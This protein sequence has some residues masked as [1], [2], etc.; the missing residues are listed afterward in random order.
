MKFYLDVDLV[1]AEDN[2]NVFADTDQVS[3]PVGDILVRDARGDVKHDDGALA[4]DVVAVSQ[5]AEFLLAGRVPGVEANGAKVGVEG[6]WMDL[7]TQSGY[8]VVSHIL[9]RGLNSES[10]LK[11]PYRRISFQTRP[12][13]VS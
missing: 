5:T 10:S 12:S 8:P 9:F 2:G 4:L 13:N 1:S 11:R 6:Q 7:D 3:V